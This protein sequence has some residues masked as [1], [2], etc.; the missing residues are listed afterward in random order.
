MQTHGDTRSAPQRDIRALTGLR[1]VAATWVVLFHLLAF[2]GPYL[3]PFGAVQAIVRSGWVGVELFFVLSGFVIALAYLDRMGR[4]PRLRGTWDFLVSRFARVWPAWAVVTVVMGAFVYGLRSRGL[5]ADV[6]APHPDADLPEL[7]RQLTMTQMWDRSALTGA[8]FVPPGWSISAEWTAYLAFPLLALLASRL[9]RLPGLVLLLLSVAAMAPLSV[10]AF[11]LGTPDHDQNWVLRIACGFT[12]GILAA[13]AV[14][15]LR[16]DARA[17]RVAP[18]AVRGSVVCVVLG[19]LWGSWRQGGDWSVDYSATVV[20]VFPVLIAAL[21]LSERGLARRLSSRPLVYGGRISYCLYLVHFPVVELVFTLPWQGQD[22]RWVLTPGQALLTPVLVGLSFLGAAALHH[23]VEEPARRL[24]LRLAGARRAPARVAVP[25][26][27]VVPGDPTRGGRA[28][29]PRVPGDR[30]VVPAPRAAAGP[31]T[32]APLPA[33]A[34]RNRAL[35]SVASD[36]REHRLSATVR[37]S[38]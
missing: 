5:D 1:A 33:H 32:A 3:A 16:A 18:A 12:A 38:T 2:S 25:A 20:V 23:G 13:L 15:R 36:A 24:V 34:V 17:E 37:P 4:R 14:R 6:I 27:T 10:T 29:T 35:R 22:E 11:V 7:L 31:R 30:G 9:Q 8:S 28:V 19:L 21:S 26:V